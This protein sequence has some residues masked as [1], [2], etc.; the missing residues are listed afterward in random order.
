MSDN[1]DLNFL[2]IRVSQGDKKAF[3]D[4]Y[5][6]TC[7]KLFGIICRILKK[8]E[9]AEEALQDTYVKIWQQASQFDPKISSPITWMATIARNRAIDIGR[10][11]QEQ[12]ASKSDELEPSL[13]DEGL[14]PLMSTIQNDE[15]RKLN[16]CLDQLSAD[17]K[18]M[19]LLAYYEG[20]AREELGS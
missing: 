20:W 12:I 14:S 15:L 4:L 7:L 19:I 16:A 18:E 1:I 3:S 2:I 11:K 17:K 9:L 10:L 13:P 6:K 5:D 8:P